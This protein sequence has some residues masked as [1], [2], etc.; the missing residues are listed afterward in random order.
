MMSKARWNKVAEMLN[1]GKTRQEVK[2]ELGISQRILTQ[3]IY[4]ARLA[5]A[6]PAFRAS[7]T[8]PA[9]KAHHLMKNGGKRVGSLMLVF[10]TL[11]EETARWLI[12]Q[13]PEGGTLAETIAAIMT[14]AYFEENPDA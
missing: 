2:S 7:P 10:D 1:A 11:S 9:D 6:I 12:Q 14:D 13:V 4:R 3:D 5:G 8:T